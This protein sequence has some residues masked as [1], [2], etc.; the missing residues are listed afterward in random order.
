MTGVVAVAFSEDLLIGLILG[1]FLGFLVGPLIRA[2]LSWREWVSASRAAELGRSREADVFAE[3]V[4]R[5]DVGVWPVLGDPE[6]GDASLPG[7]RRDAS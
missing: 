2:W 4:D 5:I 6:K 7:K 3:L 1:S